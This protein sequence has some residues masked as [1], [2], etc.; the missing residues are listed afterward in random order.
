M[1]TF[2]CH[3]I[4]NGCPARLIRHGHVESTEN[5]VHDIRHGSRPEPDGLPEAS[6]ASQKGHRIPES[7]AKRNQST[8]PCR[9]DRHTTS[10]ELEQRSKGRRPLS[11]KVLHIRK[12]GHPFAH[13]TKRAGVINTEP[14]YLL[15]VLPRSRNRGSQ[16]V[17]MLR[18][19]SASVTLSPLI[20]NQRRRL[21]LLCTNP[22]RTCSLDA[23]EDNPTTHGNQP[24]ASPPK[25]VSQRKT[26]VQWARVLSP[27]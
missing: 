24:G 2:P 16:T 5:V 18:K 26:K 13:A 11:A 4:R 19:E 15:D 25:L 10:D 7:T 20:T 1:A 12:S 17:P 23:L 22:L 21:R 8:I 14:R 27:L 6:P 9:A 3:P